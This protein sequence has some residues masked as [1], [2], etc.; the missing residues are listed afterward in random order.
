MGKGYQQ[1]RAIG[2]AAPNET[3]L[4]GRGKGEEL[5][6]VK[7]IRYFEAGKTT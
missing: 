2:A 1:S 5:D 6:G 4:F 7:R 3:C